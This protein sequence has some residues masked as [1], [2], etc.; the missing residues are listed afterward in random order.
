MVTIRVI[1]PRRGPFR[2][3]ITLAIVL[4]ACAEASFVL[5]AGVDGGDT[6]RMM[7]PTDPGAGTGDAGCGA[8]RCNGQ[9]DDCDGQTDEGFPLG[10]VC[11]ARS[12]S[13]VL[14][15]AYACDPADAS[16]VVCAPEPG[17]SG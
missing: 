17:E 12:G 7:P 11:E 3:A 1:T 16:A 2:C 6:V 14:L 9:D 10:N 4:A 13:C 15:G 8:E 5:D